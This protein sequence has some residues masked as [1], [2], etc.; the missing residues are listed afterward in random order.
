MPVSKTTRDFE[1][2]CL[3]RGI[4]ARCL[5]TPQLQALHQQWLYEV[6]VEIAALEEQWALPLVKESAR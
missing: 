1:E 4:S 2:W 5:G 3:R 6:V